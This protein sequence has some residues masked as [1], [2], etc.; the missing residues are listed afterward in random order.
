MGDPLTGIFAALTAWEAWASRRGGRFG[1]ALSRVIAYCLAEARR[2]D[3]LV[4]EA[5]LK[6]WSAA[7]GKPFPSVQRRPI[8]TWPMTTQW[9]YY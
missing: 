2:E 7:V 3:P 6:A 1:L 9:A 8:Q 5:S 4:L